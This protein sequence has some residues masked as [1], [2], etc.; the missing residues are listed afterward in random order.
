MYFLDGRS[1]DEIAQVMGTSRSNVSRMLSVARE[2]GIVEFRLHDPDGRDAKLEG[3]LLARF[4]LA[5]VRVA[6]FS[7]GSDSLTA[8][9]NLS[10]GWLDETLRDGHTLG[11]SW[12]RTLQA[13]VDAFVAEQPRAVHVVPLVGGLSATGSLVASEELVRELARR[14][15]G[16]YHYLHGPAVLHRPVAREA[17]LA[18]PSVREG[19][20]LARAADIAVVGIGAF[21]TGSSAQMFDSLELNPDERRRFLGRQPVG[22]TC[23]RFFDAAGREVPNGVQDRVLAVD[24]ADLRAI[25]TVMGVAAGAH[26]APAVL[27][28][29]RGGLVR[30]LTLDASLAHALLVAN[31]PTT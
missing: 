18:E 28:A 6:T 8:V 31:T 12:G 4:G 22:D 17:L 5:A 26:K 3:A 10:A 7:P 13:T 29:L 11:I 23:C 16:T 30:S 1:Q 27:A 24:L 14:I 19:L 20:A 21:G 9:G 25:P 2:Q 15:G